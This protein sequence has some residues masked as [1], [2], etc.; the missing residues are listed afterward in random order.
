[1]KIKLFSK[2]RSSYCFT[3]PTRPL[4]NTP[5]LSAFIDAVS[6]QTNCE[7]G[8]ILRLIRCLM[9]GLPWGKFQ[10]FQGCSISPMWQTTFVIWAWLSAVPAMTGHAT[11]TTYKHFPR[12]IN[13][14]TSRREIHSAWKSTLQCPR[15]QTSSSCSWKTK[16]V[17]P[18]SL[19]RLYD[20]SQKLNLFFS[21]I[22]TLSIG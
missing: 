10:V 6:F 20:Q 15:N 12:P 22:S 14:N 16:P 7:A 18:F 9:V 13:V 19:P 11:C 21:N 17:W 2:G 3:P 1:M 4:G 5:Y 8:S